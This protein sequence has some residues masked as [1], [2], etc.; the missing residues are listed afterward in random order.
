M[1]DFKMM[2]WSFII[3]MLVI[4]ILYTIFLQDWWSNDGL[5]D[6]TLEDEDEIC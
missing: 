3:M 5:N 1:G 4:W 2:L 6:F